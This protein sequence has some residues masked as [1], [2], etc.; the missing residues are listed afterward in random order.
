MLRRFAIGGDSY[1]GEY[2]LHSVAENKCVLILL[3]QFRMT[4]ITDPNFLRN[5][6]MRE[7]HALG[8]TLLIK[9][10]TAVPTVVFAVGKGERRPA[11]HADIGVGPLG[12]LSGCSLAYATTE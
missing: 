12:R 9:H 4:T 7:R 5:A 6:E 10:L 2:H 8:R 1:D 11:S 3:C